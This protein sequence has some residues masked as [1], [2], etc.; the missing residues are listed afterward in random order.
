MHATVEMLMRDN[1]KRDEAI[2]RSSSVIEGVNSENKLL[3]A[4]LREREELIDELRRQEKASESR[5]LTLQNDNLN[6]TK[7]RTVET[8]LRAELEGLRNENELI[9]EDS[10]KSEAALRKQ[11]FALEKRFLADLVVPQHG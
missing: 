1:K 8:K 6:V 7:L 4:K 10:Q 5:L 11:V 3:K 2:N 9:L